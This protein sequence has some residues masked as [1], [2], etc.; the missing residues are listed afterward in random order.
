MSQLVPLNAN[1]ATKLKK[2]TK[3][4]GRSKVKSRDSSKAS[5]L[6]HYQILRKILLQCIGIYLSFTLLCLSLYEKFLP[7]L[8]QP[9]ALALSDRLKKVNIANES[10]LFERK[11]IFT[12]IM[13]GF[14]AQFDFALTFA[15]ILAFPLLI[16]RLY[17]FIAPA[18]PAKKR[19]KIAIYLAFAPFL[20]ALGA[21]LAYFY[22]M[23]LAWKFFLSYENNPIVLNI[24]GLSNENSQKIAL[25]LRLE[26]K[27][28]EYLKSFQQMIVAFGLA[29]QLPLILLILDKIGILSRK[30]LI[31]YRRHAIVVIFIVAAILTPPDV[32]SQISL[33]L[34]MLGLY[35]LGI[36]LCRFNESNRD[37][38]KIRILKLK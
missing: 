23:P 17:S 10:G 27:I 36:F 26:A 13:E 5:F 29:F 24:P 22:A 18:L 30:Q 32:I 11:L 34:P 6:Q 38:A 21:A 7:Y 33:A 25:S 2:N 15:F 35:E 19:R 37:N 14:F 16:Q 3:K 12:H 4:S 31:Y 28:S 8:L 20:F 9:L 1:E